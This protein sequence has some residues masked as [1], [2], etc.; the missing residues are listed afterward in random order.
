MKNSKEES[1]NGG[2]ASM[3]SFTKKQN[4][5]FKFKSEYRKFLKNQLFQNYAD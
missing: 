4:R 2:S 3:L 5:L 1:S